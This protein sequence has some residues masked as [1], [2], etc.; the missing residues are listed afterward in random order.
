MAIAPTVL[1]TA[2]TAVRKAKAA[3][4][5]VRGAELFNILPINLRNSEHG[6]VP[7]F[8]NHLDIFL[9]D[10]PDQPTVAGLARGALTNSLVHQIPAYNRNFC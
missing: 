1:K 6:D 8:K 5:A 3:S 7:M 10:I 2:P 9:T 4:L